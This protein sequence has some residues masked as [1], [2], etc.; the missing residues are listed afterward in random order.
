MVATLRGTLPRLAAAFEAARAGRLTSL[1][2]NK[3]GGELAS[4]G[5]Q[6]V[7]R[8]GTASMAPAVA[9]GCDRGASR[10]DLNLRQE[11]YSSVAIKANDCST[12]EATW[13]EHGFV[14]RA[15]FCCSVV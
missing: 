10:S 3:A 7:R 14:W 6:A 2:E 15:E 1:L 8:C 4:I 9:G 12:Q 5:C 13:T 11:A